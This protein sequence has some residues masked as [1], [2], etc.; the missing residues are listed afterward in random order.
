MNGGAVT[1]NSDPA[2]NRRQTNGVAELAVGPTVYSTEC[3]VRVCRQGNRVRSTA[4]RAVRERR[5]IVIG[6]D[7]GFDQRTLAIRY[8]IGIICGDSDCGCGHYPLSKCQKQSGAGQRPGHPV[9]KPSSALLQV[10]R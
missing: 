6:V 7:D 1:F 2:G 4:R 8:N 5:S 3:Q 10:L 9:L